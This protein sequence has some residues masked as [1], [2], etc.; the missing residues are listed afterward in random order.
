MTTQQ[1]K[2]Y[3]ESDAEDDHSSDSDYVEEYECSS[4]Y[5]YEPEE[6][7]DEP[8]YNIPSH[9]TNKPTGPRPDA[10]TI[11]ITAIKSGLTKEMRDKKEKKKTLTKKMT[12]IRSY[13][14][15]RISDGMDWT[16]SLDPDILRTR[17]EYK[18]YKD[19]C[20]IHDAMLVKLEADGNV[21]SDIDYNINYILHSKT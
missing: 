3:Y 12:K 21:V 13:K 6:N 9:R 10:N 17:S 1:A 16:S 8:V 20:K 19:N 7:V 14:R 5:E 11:E 4:D 18:R 2:N 15:V